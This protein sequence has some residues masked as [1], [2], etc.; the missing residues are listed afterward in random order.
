MF[1]LGKALL[2]SVCVALCKVHMYINI[3]T[4]THMHTYIHMYHNE[5]QS[6]AMTLGCSTCLYLGRPCWLAYALLFARF[7]LLRSV[8]SG[9][10][11]RDSGCD[12]LV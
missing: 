6:W 9:N 11:M 5:S 4:H 12:L 3:Y 7:S 8:P 2:A 10:K 1:I